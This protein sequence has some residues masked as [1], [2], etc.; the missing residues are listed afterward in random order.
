MQL[1]HISIPRLIVEVGGDP[2]AINQSLQA[3]RPARISEL[4]QAFHNAGRCTAEACAAF[5]DALR[6][7]EASWKRDNGD[8]P[9]NDSV[10]VQRVANSLGLQAAQLPKIGL[11]LANIAAALAEAQRL[12]GKQIAALEAQLQEIDNELGDALEIENNVS[13]TEADKSAVDALISTLEDDA[14]TETKVALQKLT[15]IR[16]GYSDDLQS[17]LSTLNNDGCDPT[18]IEAFDAPATPTKGGPEADRRQTEI[19]A[20]AK[21]FGRPPTS[22][23]DWQ[24]AAALDPHSYDPKNGGVPPNI[25]VGRI[26]PVPGQGVVRTNLFIPGRAVWAPQLDWQ[27][28]HDNLGD[29]RGFSST[30]GPEA[31]RVSIY[32]DYENGIIVARQNPSV[33]AKTGQI[34]AG[35]PTISA[36]Q[37][38]DG[39]VLVKY[40]AADPFSPGGEGLAKATSFDVNG[41]IAIQPTPG[42]PHVGGTV[43]NFPAIEIYNDRPGSTTAPLVQSW[44]LVVDNAL[45]PAAGLWWH[46]SI[47]DQVL[48][49]RFNDQYPALTIPSLPQPGH[50]PAPVPIGPP[51]VATP[52]GT[53]LLGPVDHP[54]EIGLH[55]PVVMLPPLLPR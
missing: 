54:P 4:A 2:W 45:G 43:T 41:T 18:M 32:V 14:I 6:R 5:D 49:L 50:G 31:S 8:H 29:N 15:S 48:E 25:V 46:R 12:A 24:T 13:L 33:D 47:G 30:A 1:R 37:K 17:S 10:E 52:P 28:I 9:I 38:S 55:D 7:F 16:S 26:K 3:G 27:P 21:I 53:Y 40:S 51:L 36:V 22:A 11:H 39:G 23:A 35:T 19:A 44:P 34:R 20:F 42:G